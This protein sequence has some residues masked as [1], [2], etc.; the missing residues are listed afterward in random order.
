MEY[1]TLHNGD[2]V[3]AIGQG[4]WRLGGGMQP[5]YSED[6][7]A[8]NA[9]RQAIELG[10]THIDTAEMY[11][12]GHTEE[13]VA[14]AIKPF[15]RE[16]LFIASKIWKVT[17]DPA[18]ARRALEGSLR[19]LQTDYLDMY[20]FHRPNLDAPLEAAFQ[21]LNLAVRQGMIRHLGVCNF[22]LEQIHYAQ[23]LS[24]TQ[25]AAVQVPYNL[26]ERRYLVNGVIPYCQENG[27][28]VQAYSPLERGYLLEDPQLQSM[29]NRYNATPAQLALYWLVRQPQVVPLPMSTRRAH[30]EE[31]LKALDLQL[32]PGDQK[33]LDLLELPEDRLWPE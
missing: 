27:V 28:L 33:T 31:N 26:H 6:E 29:A 15:P 14:Q 1:K 30:L 32:S 24:A 8:I 3:A 7:M 18:D 16:Q 13:L 5:D 25:L 9:I 11:G 10:Y 2:R 19:R 17:Q 12:G 21:A 4:T 23:R 22:S 20:L